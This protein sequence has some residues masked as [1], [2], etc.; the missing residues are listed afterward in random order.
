M[1]DGQMMGGDSNFVQFHQIK[2]KSESF[3]VNSPLYISI[4]TFFH[5]H[6]DLKDAEFYVLFWKYILK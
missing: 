5:Y 4:S 3:R 6:H 2:L 1:V